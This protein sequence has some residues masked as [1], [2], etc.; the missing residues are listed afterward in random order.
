MGLHEPAERRQA[1]KFARAV[2]SKPDDRKGDCVVLQWS[3]IL[4]RANLLSEDAGGGASAATHNGRPWACCPS[5]AV[6]AY[7]WATILMIKA[8]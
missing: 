8:C 1:E 7:W 5:P 6:P 3:D 4:M 2:F